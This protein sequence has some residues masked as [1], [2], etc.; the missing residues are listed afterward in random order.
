MSFRRLVGFGEAMLRL[1]V[2]DGG[3][4]ETATRLDCSVGG[5]ELNACVAAV[6][7]GMPATWVGAL[8]DDPLARL[9]RR[10]VRANGVDAE[11]V[12][13]EHAR[14][15][16]YFLEMAPP[17][18]PLRITY[19]RRGSAFALLEPDRIDWPKLLGPDA[20]LLLTGITPPLGTGP[21]KAVEH[22]LTAA[23]EVGATVALD[24]NYRSALWSR[25]EASRWVSAV[26]PEVD[27]LS[28]GPD[29][30][31]AVG[32][33]GTDPVADALQRFE[34]RAV[35]TTSKRRVDDVLE[36]EVRVVTPDGEHRGESRVVVVDP[37][38]A[39]DA[40]FGTFLAHL[41]RGDVQAATELGLSAAV[42]CVGLFGDALVDDPWD[43]SEESGVVR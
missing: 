12:T 6:R 40:L 43:A 25:E 17:P 34:L 33:E 2:R 5:A 7:A 10:H 37:I 39:G 24:V 27:V 18:R 41:P 31:L 8:P 42:T 29:D 30:L 36:L 16:L 19:D 21:R 20:C 15:G 35:M 1:T 11:I 32:L 23:R 28:A 13:V 38:G 26:L 14:L 22:A 4:I 3:A 9:V